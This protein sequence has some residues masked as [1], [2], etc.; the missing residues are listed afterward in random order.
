MPIS[1]INSTSPK[2]IAPCGINCRLC[3][4]YVRVGKSIPCPG[5]RGDNTNKA[6]SCVT[7]KIKNCVENSGGK[8]QYCFECELFPCARLKQ[9]DKRYKTK[10]GTSPIQNLHSIKE[11]G[12]RK[13]VENE[14]K[15]WTCPECGT[16]LCMHIPQCLSC[17]HVWHTSS[18]LR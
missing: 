18:E 13:F 2:L 14:N 8:F 15:K 9:L 5:C 10:Y 12:I 4:A 7:C 11:I 16:M 1:K 17:G 6:R 3:R